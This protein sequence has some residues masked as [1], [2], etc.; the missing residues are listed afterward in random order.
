MDASFRI[1]INIFRTQKLPMHIFLPLSFS[2]YI[3]H[4]HTHTHISNTHRKAQNKNIH[5]RCSICRRLILVI[6]IFSLCLPSVSVSVSF[7]ACY[8]SF[9][10]SSL[11]ICARKEL[12]WRSSPQQ[13]L[14]KA[15]NAPQ[16]KRVLI[17]VC[18]F[19]RFVFLC[20]FLLSF[21]FCLWY[22]TFG[23]CS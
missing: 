4:T 12:M 23:P 16:E 22:L 1:I 6:S 17:P 10:I 19:F 15:L 9:L 18:F 2:L 13:Q 20:L 7:F 8:G 21:Y 11:K 14:Q 3:T 5:G